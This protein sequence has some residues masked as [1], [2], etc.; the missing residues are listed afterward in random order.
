MGVLSTIRASS[1]ATPKRSKNH[2]SVVA[3]PLEVHLR[4]VDDI[5]VYEIDVYKRIAQ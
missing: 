5:T 1:S 3:K 4:D 2:S